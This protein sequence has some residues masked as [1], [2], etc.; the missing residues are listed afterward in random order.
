[1]NDMMNTKK[2][3]VDLNDVI[4]ELIDT[5]QDSLAF[6]GENAGG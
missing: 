6:S 5:Y 4:N 1:M 2:H 3:D